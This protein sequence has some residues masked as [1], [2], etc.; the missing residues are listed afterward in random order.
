[1]GAGTSFAFKEY[2]DG[3]EG[4]LTISDGQSVAKLHL[5]GYYAT[6]DFALASD[7]HGGALVTHP[8][9]AGE[10]VLGAHLF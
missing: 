1:M 8:L 10:L 9:G 6:G 5:L 3:I 2:A 4:D 7:G